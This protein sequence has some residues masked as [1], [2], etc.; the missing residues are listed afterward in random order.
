VAAAVLSG[1]ISAAPAQETSGWQPFFSI[2]GAYEG[3]GDI[4][5][6][7]DFSVWNTALRAGARRDLGGGNG[8]GV[9]LNY[10]YSDYS[11]SSPVQFGGV[12]PWNI[13]QRYGVAVPLSFG[14]SDGWSLGFTPS[15]DWFRENGADF[16]DS[17]VWGATFSGTRRFAD[18]NRFGVGIGVFDRLE[19]TGIYPFFIVDWRFNDRWR[20][21]N[22]LAAGPTGPAGL[23]LDYRLG[24]GWDIGAGFAYRTFRF[25][26]SES[27]AVANGVGEQRGLP[28]FLRA[29]YAV[30]DRMSLHLYAGVVTS[31]ELRVEDA[32]GNTLRKVDYDP[33]PIVGATFTARF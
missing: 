2:T 24:G 22:P 15:A 28:L 8:I 12:A 17:L 31:G 4:D 9:S 29:T 10:D 11:F 13:V 33:A 21:I 20:L 32:N 19:K 5:G 3:K 16:G 26:L 27:G 7:G 1:G 25:R 14:L 30:R 6:G 18:G 23:E